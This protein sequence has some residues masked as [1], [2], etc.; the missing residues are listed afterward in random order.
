LASSGS[1]RPARCAGNTEMARRDGRRAPIAVDLELLGQRFGRAA[2]AKQHGRRTGCLPS[3]SSRTRRPKAGPRRR[4]A[5]R[6]QTGAPPSI[7]T[8][9]GRWHG[10][11][12]SLTSFNPSRSSRE[13]REFFTGALAGLDHLARSACQEGGTVSADRVEAV[14]ISQYA[15]CRD[16][17]LAAVGDILV[18]S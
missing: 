11:T 2:R 12:P 17:V 4:R 18:G 8:F 13:H 16:S 9:V 10:R 1:G 6:Q 3:I 15:P 7:R 5:P 14:M